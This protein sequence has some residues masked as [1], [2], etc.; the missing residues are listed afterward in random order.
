M[1]MG[2][3]EKT[4]LAGMR[5]ERDLLIGS[6][7]VAIGVLAFYTCYLGGRGIGSLIFG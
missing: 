7:Y 4:P 6:L 5:A 1:H 2:N 3:N